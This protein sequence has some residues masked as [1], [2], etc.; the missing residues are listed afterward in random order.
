MPAV[1]SAYDGFI[2]YSHAADGQLA[3]ALERGLETLAKPWY[4]RRALSI[5]RDGTSLSATPE[6]WS[7]IERALERSRFF[8]LLASPEAAASAWVD[9]EVGWWLDHRD[10]SSLLVVLTGGELAWDHTAGD[11][12]WARTDA[13]PARLR[14]RYAEEPLWVD[15]RW[16]QEEEQ[17]SPRDP[18]FR[19]RV[20]DLAAPLHDKP[21]DELIGE[22]IRLHRRAIRLARAT[23]A[24][25]V[26]LAA[27]AT[28]AAVV[29][30]GQRNAAREQTQLA[31]SR[32]LAATAQNNLESNLDLGSL[33]AVEAWRLRQTPQ[34]EAALFQAATSSPQ[35]VRFLHAGAPVTALAA[36][37][38][39]VAAGGEG[40]SVS[41]WTDAGR[42][43]VDLRLGNAPIRALTLST[44]G[45]HLLAGSDSGSVALFDVATG[46]RVWRETAHAEPVTAVA[47]ASDANWA[48]SADEGGMLIV[49]DANGVIHG[50]V[51]NLPLVPGRVA[52][53]RGSVIMVGSQ[54]GSIARWQLPGLSPVQEP[55]FSSTPASDYAAAYSEDGSTFAFAKF[56]AITSLDTRTGVR[57]SGFTKSDFP[58]T[59][60]SDANA[61]TVSPKGRRVAVLGE[62]AITVLD[63]LPGDPTQAAAATNVLTGFDR[64]DAQLV[65]AEEGSRFVAGSGSTVAV[66]DLEQQSRV[67]RTLEASVAELYGPANPSPLA[68]RP[69]GSQLVWAQDTSEATAEAELVCWDLEAAQQDPPVRLESPVSALAYSPDGEKLA[70]GGATGVEIWASGGG[71]PRYEQTLSVPGVPGPDGFTTVDYVGFLDRARL[72]TRTSE[73]VVLVVDAREGGVLSTLAEASDFDAPERT[74]TLT[75]SGGRIALGRFDG[76]V[77]IVEPSGTRKVVAAHAGPVHELSFSPGGGLLASVDANGEVMLVDPTDGSIE[78]RLAGGRPRALSFVAGGS[79][80]VGV[81]HGALGTGWDPVTGERLGTMPTQ[82]PTLAQTS[83]VG[84]RTTLEPDGDGHLWISAPGGRPARWDFSLDAWVSVACEIAGRELTEEEWRQYVGTDPPGD[85]DCLRGD[86]DSH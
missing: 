72:L 13:L 81:G 29:A 12:D 9:R 60:P 4:R 53:E 23:G 40:G 25:L 32:Q 74:M 50:T 48:A 76:R 75:H 39:T 84:W 1:D 73:G 27:A 52:F 66:W 19:E 54:T 41:L 24:A 18:R 57:V 14:G 17:L 8:L 34:S 10:Q 38:T 79:L 68:V 2:S 58:A 85:R 62:G 80:L 31:L 30:V 26:L 3:P 20:A 15:L 64:D 69:D 21:K 47:L 16:A 71:C 59:A 83:D 86:A 37:G 46:R 55:S 35:L 78:R 61:I 70:F 11:F 77:V 7:T 44:D 6:L 33:L 67:T 5:F 63:R 36:N 42:D 28:L 43:R 82:P 51:E 65:F 22:D 49:S 56:G 45:Q